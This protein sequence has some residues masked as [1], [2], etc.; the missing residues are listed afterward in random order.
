MRMK[1]F[2]LGIGVN[3]LDIESALNRGDIEGIRISPSLSPLD[4]AQVI[5]KMRASAYSK[6]FLELLASEP[7]SDG[8]VWRALLEEPVDTGVAMTALGN[9]MIPQEEVVRL[10][11]HP[12]SQVQGHA[13]L[14]RLQH[15]IPRLGEAELNELLDAHDGDL[16][17]SLGVRHLVARSPS[18]PRRIL[19]RLVDDDADFIADR[20]RRQL[21]E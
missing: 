17:V 12:S 11:D 20:A 21:E 15:Q 10:L 2:E 8:T 13:L 16:G 18:T 9:A 5:T 6:I 14:A 1:E 7:I 3:G 19:L 4:L